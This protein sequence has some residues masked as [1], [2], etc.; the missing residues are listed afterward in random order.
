MNK[1]C[2]PAWLPEKIS[3]LLFNWFFEASCITHDKAYGIGGNE[4]K[5]YQVDLE[6]WQ[7][8]RRDTLRQKGFKRLARWLQALLFF[9]VVRLFGWVQFNYL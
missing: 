1:G 7:A 6:F 2:G 5:R 4:S 3:D 8:M 9:A